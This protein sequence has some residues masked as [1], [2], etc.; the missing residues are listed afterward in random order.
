MKPGVNRRPSSEA[1]CRL[2]SLEESLLD[3]VLRISLI[4][5]KEKGRAEQPI[6]ARPDEFLHSRVFA[7]FECGDQFL[8]I[9]CNLVPGTRKGFK[10]ARRGTG[11]FESLPRW[12]MRNTEAA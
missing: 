11:P 2:Q 10:R 3:E 8:L 12:D 7:P 6:A 1:M 4:A 9:H 5:A